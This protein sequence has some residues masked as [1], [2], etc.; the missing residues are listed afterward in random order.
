VISCFVVDLVRAAV[1]E[2]LRFHPRVVQQALAQDAAA[3]ERLATMLPKLVPFRG[4][5]VAKAV[6]I[7][8][9]D[10]RL[11]SRTLTLRLHL[12]YDNAGAERFEKSHAARAAEIAKKDLFPEFDVPDYSDLA[13][14]ESYD[15]DL[16][17]E[18]VVDAMRL[19]S[20]WRREVDPDLATAAVRAVRASAAFARAKSSTPT[21]PPHLG[22]LE[23]VAW[24]PPCESGQPR[25]TIDVWW[26]TA[27][28]GRVGKGWSFLVDTEPVEGDAP[29][30]K[31]VATREFTVRTA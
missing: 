11:P 3:R 28:D 22:D 17:L 13:G 31:I 21:R 20:P 12:L 30:K 4:R 6:A 8:D 10:H 14:D 2:N 25:W 7:L 24:M 18:L 9:W 16:T 29:D 26:L 15:A 19:T 5:S 23:A 1:V 27:F